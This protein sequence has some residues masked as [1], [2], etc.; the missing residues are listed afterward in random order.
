MKE[1]LM[2]IEHIA[3]LQG[4]DHMLFLLALVAWASLGDV[5]RV[6]LLATA[7]TLGHTLTLLLAGMG[8]AHPFGGW[9]E[10]LIPVTIFCT[11]LWNL[12]RTAEQG[13]RRV[14]RVTYAMTIVFGLVHGLGFSR[15]FRMMQDEGDGLVLPLLRFN[16]GVE[17][18]QAALLLGFLAMASLLR[19]IG[20]R[21]REQQVF[22]CAA[23]GAVALLMALER[24]PF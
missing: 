12:R 22:V 13:S 1:V 9:I 16:V 4:Y 7:F 11:A 15:F 8:W 3:D 23:T 14:N 6:L 19:V 20:V 18:G 2:G 21:Q 17:I 5:L 10:F 24:S